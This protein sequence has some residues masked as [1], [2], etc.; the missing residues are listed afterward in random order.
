MQK[1]NFNLETNLYPETFIIQAIQ[2]FGEDFSIEYHDGTLTI[3]EEGI[4]AIQ[5]IFDEFMNYVLGLIN[6]QF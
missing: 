5:T 2:D 1:Q 6:E 3:S 4:Q